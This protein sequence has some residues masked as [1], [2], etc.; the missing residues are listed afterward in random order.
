MPNFHKISLMEIADLNYANASIS[1]CNSP[2]CLATW[3]A[4]CT[5]YPT[6]EFKSVIE[7]C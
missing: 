2:K 6:G 4:Q 3:A 1:V 5:P 7:V